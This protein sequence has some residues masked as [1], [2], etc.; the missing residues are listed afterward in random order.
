M[1]AS[2]EVINAKDKEII[3]F[4]A[5]VKALSESKAELRALLV[6]SFFRVWWTYAT[7]TT[8]VAEAKE[9]VVEKD[10]E[11]RARDS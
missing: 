5:E 1:L 6:S 4:K 3:G 7:Y 2:Q 11:L 8:R 9:A 10:R